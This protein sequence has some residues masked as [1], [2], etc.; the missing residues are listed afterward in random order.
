MGGILTAIGY[1]AYTLFKDAPTV[2]SNLEKT[3]AAFEST[4]SKF[5]RWR[6]EDEAW[7]GT[8]SSFPEGYVDMG[9]MNLSD[10][11]LRLEIVADQGQ[12][13]GVIAT[14][15]I[16]QALPVFDFLLIK[17]E[18]SGGDAKI[19]VYDFIDGKRKEFARLALRRE[20][21]IMTVTPIEGMVDWFPKMARIGHHPDKG[22]PLNGFCKRG[23][24]PEKAGKQKGKRRPV[25]ELHYKGDGTR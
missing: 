11:D 21:R 22:E 16:C 6:Y 17:G 13:G 7:S 3:P 8:W 25:T 10:V 5:L 19:T 24:S 12:I 23:V 14:G 15:K 9:D 18:V 1:I 2:L 4:K 20:G